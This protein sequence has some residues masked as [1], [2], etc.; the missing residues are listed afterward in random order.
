MKRQ[1][2]YPF[3]F[4]S[5]ACD[6][7]LGNCCTGSS[8]YIWLTMPEIENIAA[9]LQIS[10]SEMIKKYTYR[11][12]GKF[13]LE[14]IQL[15]KGNY[16][17]IFFKDRCTIYEVRPEQCRTFPFWPHFKKRPREVIRE[18]PG[19]KLNGDKKR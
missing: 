7:C 13:S 14:E 19:V 12:D 10:V 18:C 3:V 9:Y 16:A 6:S 1:K 8:G 5:T 2:G 11:E 4:D 15:S 17:C